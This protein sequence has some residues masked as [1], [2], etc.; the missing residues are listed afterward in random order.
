MKMK[1]KGE[2]VKNEGHGEK[3]RMNKSKKLFRIM[4]TT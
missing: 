3:E 1:G 2:N 4:I